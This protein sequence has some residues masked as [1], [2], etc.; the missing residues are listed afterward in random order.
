MLLI[1]F[2][3]LCCLNTSMDK[4]MGKISNLQIDLL[5]VKSQS[6][7]ALQLKEQSGSPKFRDDR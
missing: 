3:Q 4:L 6:Y 7:A 1:K 2:V 5:A